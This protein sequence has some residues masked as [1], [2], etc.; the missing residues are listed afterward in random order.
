MYK[1]MW[2]DLSIFCNITILSF[3][4]SSRNLVLFA[5]KYKVIRNLIGEKIDIEK[6][7]IDTRAQRKILRT[8]RCDWWNNCHMMI[9]I[10][11]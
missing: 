7:L 4:R 2:L 3:E 5:F 11:L 9:L 1:F 8:R 6:L 10:L